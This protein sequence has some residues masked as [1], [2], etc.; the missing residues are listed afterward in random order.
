MRRTLSKK[1]ILIE[2]CVST[3]C[4][5]SINIL[6]N[7]SI[8]VGTTGDYP[9]LTYQVGSKYRGIDIDIIIDFAKINHTAIKF[10][11]TTWQTMSQDLSEGKFDVAVGGI[12][13]SP[14]RIRL[15]Y[16]SIPIQAL[17]KVPLIR[18][19]KSK[20]F[21]TFANIDSESIVVVENRGGTNENFALQHIKHAILVLIPQ[22]YKA[23]ASLSNLKTP[24]DVMFTDNIE[25]QYQHTINPT[26]CVANIPEKFPSG[27]KVFLFTKTKN[28]FK[29]QQS[30][31]QWWQL[32][33]L[34]YK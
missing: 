24:T 7:N 3:T 32:N 15:F 30:F 25:A 17:T 19:N 12:S 14:E 33:K 1:L 22:N 27:N 11:P 28:G 18:C 26:L 13:D 4:F 29:L 34:N 10:I 6:T 9:P 5:A 16:L 21:T 2:L 31:N 20:Y 8:L 23:L